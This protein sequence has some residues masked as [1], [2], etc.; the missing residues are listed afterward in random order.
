[1][2]RTL[3]ANHCDWADVLIVHGRRFGHHRCYYHANIVLENLFWNWSKL[4]RPYV[5]YQENKVPY[6]K[7]DI[8]PQWFNKGFVYP[9]FCQ[10][11]VVGHHCKG[12]HR[13]G[14]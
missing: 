7:R 5:V 1:M 10:C 11:H 2:V 6:H 12:W 14:T 8:V 9:D 4:K 3:F 13:P